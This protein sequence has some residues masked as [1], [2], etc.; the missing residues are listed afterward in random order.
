MPQPCGLECVEDGSSARDDSHLLPARGCLGAS[1]RNQ[2]DTGLI[3]SLN[4][5]QIE[6]EVSPDV[7]GRLAESLLQGLRSR[8]VQVTG[9][10][11]D[12]ATAGRSRVSDREADTHY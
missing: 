11:E 12:E 2:P 8:S 3:H 10:R 1:R 4:V 7:F 5:R 6:Q 9:D